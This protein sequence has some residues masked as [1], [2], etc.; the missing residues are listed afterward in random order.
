MKPYK[1]LAVVFCLIAVSIF[2][3]SVASYSGPDKSPGILAPCGMSTSPAVSSRY[4]LGIVTMPPVITLGLTYRSPQ[5]YPPALPPLYGYDWPTSTPSAPP[6]PK[7]IL[8]VPQIMPMAFPHYTGLI[9][10]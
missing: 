9:L 7:S 6:Q 1:K 5:L 4:G 3:L 10:T 2:C 8:S